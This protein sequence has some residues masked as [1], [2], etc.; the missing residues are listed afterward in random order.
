MSEFA[1]YA[2][3][4]VPDGPLAAFG[5]AWL[6]W[7]VAQGAEVPQPDL[8]P[9]G[10]ELRRITDTPRKYGF[11]G[12][13]KPPFRLAEG[14]SAEQLAEETQDLARR[15]AP[16]R[17]GGLAPGR[18]GRFL[19]L[20]PQGDTAALAALAAA[21]VTELDGFRETLSEAEL[22][23][24]RA[25]GLTDRQEDLLAAWG[26]PYVLDEFRFHMTLSGRVDDSTA[27]RAMAALDVALPALDTPYV[28]GAI[29][30]VGE[31]ADGRFQTIHRYALTG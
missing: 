20:V 30:L 17:V 1:R 8:P 15:T 27:A 2:I 7:D 31:R 18:I 4:Y 16:V 21:C 6:G 28:F 22:A 9:L 26:Y 10:D 25:A 11:H 19:A 12:T 5:A 14:R 29:A 3:Y 13:L 23:R 24:R